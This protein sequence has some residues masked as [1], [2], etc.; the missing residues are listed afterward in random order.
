MIEVGPDEIGVGDMSG[1]AGSG[2]PRR[3]GKDRFDLASYPCVRVR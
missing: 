2:R 1:L 3:L